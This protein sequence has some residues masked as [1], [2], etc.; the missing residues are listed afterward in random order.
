[1]STRPAAGSASSAASDS[2]LA[3]FFRYH[4]VWAPGVRLFRA[5]GFRAKAL[6]ISLVFAIPI[7]VLAYSYFGDKR[8]AIDFSSKERTGIVY[9]RAVMPLVKLLQLNR[10]RSVAGSIVADDTA[11]AN[12]AWSRLAAL[13]VA[14]GAELGTAKAHAAFTAAAAAAARAD[15]KA[16]F[17]AHG[18]AIQAALDLLGVST[19]G[20][21]L[22]LDPD[23]DTYYLMDAAM[24]R[25]PVM[26]EAAGQLRG[27]GSAV[28]SAGKASPEQWRQMVEQS[29]TL[30]SNLAAVK[31]GLDKAVA[32]NPAVRGAV[33]A[34]QAMEAQA[35]LLARIDASL[36]AEAG[37]QGQ[38]PE[39]VAAATRVI[40]LQFALMN[41]AT[42][43]LDGLIAARVDGLLAGRNL[44]AGVL[45]V[46]L[47]LVV[48]LFMAFRKVLD[49]GLREVAFHIQAM[50]DGDLTTQPRAW[51]A[52][53]AASLMHTLVQMQVSLRGIVGQVRGASDNIVH[54]TGEISAG[55]MD[56]SARTEQAAAN[57][58][59]SASAME[60]IAATVRSTA[61]SAVEASRLAT[62]NAQL[63][64]QGGRII[65]SMVSTMQDIHASSSKIN[66][67]IGVIDGIAF[68]TNILA[69]NAAVEAARAGDAGRGFAVVA[70]EVR[71]LSQRSSAAAREIKSLIQTSVQRVE[72]GASI[73]GQAGRT[74]G[75][76]V[77]SAG[78]VN[79]LLAQISTGAREQAGGVTQTTRAVQDMDTMTQQNAALVEQ[80]AAAADSLKGQAESL[81][82]MVSQFK[83]P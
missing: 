70:S 55:S 61:D 45:A 10:L 16:A 21:N 64:E 3:D 73:V 71:G 11:G 39:H 58:E 68:Q 62:G 33:D 59:E 60:Q 2:R 19:D 14:H 20:S 78:Q 81:A 52:D 82:R 77:E 35:A 41:R 42:D 9:A 54:S 8:S 69:L 7:A 25:L 32:Y 80:T 67:I 38:A 51:G 13:E 5:I 29:A 83:L 53:E 79:L 1:M 76:I 48:Y 18:A 23:I 66:D 57:L 27:M 43:A 44:T 4:G 37:V 75:E 46:S 22:T 65:G 26:I 50:R 31:G 28:L 34:D 56:L 49:G 24:F 30:R 15:A 12:A 74:I 47:V 6:V 40:E 72:A 17:A 36:L 63:A